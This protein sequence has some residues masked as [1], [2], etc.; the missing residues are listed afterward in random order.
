MYMRTVPPVSRVLTTCVSPVLSEP[1]G[2]VTEGAR[3]L[4]DGIA[5][6]PGD[7]DII[8]ING[9]G[10]PAWRGGPM[11]YADQIGV[12]AV[13]EKVCE[14]R[15]RFGDRYWHPPKLLETLAQDGGSFS[16]LSA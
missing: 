1:P 7:I 6:R 2:L 5:L 14:F 9:Y 12:A 16:D 4:E 10:F 3:I 8:W 15:D 11:H 13:Y